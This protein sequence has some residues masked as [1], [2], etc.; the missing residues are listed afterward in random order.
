MT[1]IKKK[2]KKYG[3]WF[4]LA[5]CLSWKINDFAMTINQLIK[6]FVTAIKRFIKD[7]CNDFVI[8]AYCQLK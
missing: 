5:L 1:N 2:D 4:L 6:V 3:G 7:A 8:V